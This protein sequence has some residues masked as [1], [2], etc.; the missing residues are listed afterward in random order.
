MTVKDD[1]V[2]DVRRR[3][4]NVPSNRLLTQRLTK[5]DFVDVPI[6]TITP[7][8]DHVCHRLSSC[9]GVVI[10]LLQQIW[11]ARFCRIF[12]CRIETL[13]APFAAQPFETV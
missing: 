12:P 7:D 10:L 4:D 13:L 8:F 1:A 2:R 5:I 3:K 11:H 9:V 6:W